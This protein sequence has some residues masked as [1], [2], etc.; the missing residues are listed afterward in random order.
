MEQ[1]VFG[2]WSGKGEEADISAAAFDGAGFDA[3]GA[4]AD[5]VRG[6]RRQD[7]G[8]PPHVVACAQ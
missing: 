8:M 1:T 6:Q 4:V 2:F 5:D 7:R 3:I